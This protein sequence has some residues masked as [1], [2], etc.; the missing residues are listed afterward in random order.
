MFFVVT[1][2]RS[3]SKTL[4]RVL[5]QH[6]LCRCRHEPHQL[7]I[8]LAADFVHGQMDDHETLTYLTE[9]RP[10]LPHRTGLVF[11]GESDHRVSFLIPQLQTAL[12]NS[13]RFIWQL[14]DG[15]D[16]VASTFSRKWYTEEEAQNP[17]NL[18]AKYRIR[19]DLAGDVPGDI[20]RTMSRFEKCCWY[21]T[22]TNHTIQSSFHRMDRT[23]WFMLRLEE[24]PDHLPTLLQFLDLPYYPLEI[25]HAN[26]SAAQ[27]HRTLAWTDEQ[28]AAF[29]HWCGQAMDAWYPGWRNP[30]AFIARG[31]SSPA[32]APMS[33]ST[34]RVLL[35]HVGWAAKKVG[36]RLTIKFRNA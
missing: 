3:G 25:V 9:I 22:Y 1:T 36:H 35:S 21:W 6:P 19:G 20:W 15:R 28:H 16:V 5:D 30:D 34:L 13:A 26:R 18:W 8:K 11:N 33:S 14:R 10:L 2:G 23:R 12:Q 29:E 17:H 4:A 32:A 7:F 24:L 27:P 31:S